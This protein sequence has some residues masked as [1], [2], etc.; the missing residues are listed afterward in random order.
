MVFESLLNPKKAEQQPWMTFFLGFFC[1]TIAIFLGNYIFLIN[2]LLAIVFLTTLF[3]IPLFYMT[4]IYEEKKDLASKSGEKGLLKEHSKALS[5]FVFL[6]LGMTLSFMLWY[7]VFSSTSFTGID[8]SMSFQIQEEFL[9][10]TFRH[11]LSILRCQT[12]RD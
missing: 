8:P 1:V 9:V 3:F 6:F 7:I 12:Q 11:C 4:M 5:F 2:S 10:A